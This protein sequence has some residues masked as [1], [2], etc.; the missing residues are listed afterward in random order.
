MPKSG[1]KTIRVT[2][3][4][5]LGLYQRLGYAAVDTRLPATEI[6]RRALEAYLP[7]KAREE[8]KQP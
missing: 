2:A 1:D 7:V 3:I 4:L 8:G 6:I 5:P